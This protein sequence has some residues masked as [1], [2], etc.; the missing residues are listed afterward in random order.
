MITASTE[1]VEDE[2]QHSTE[3]VQNGVVVDDG[4]YDHSNLHEVPTVSY[5]SDDEEGGY[6]DR[7][8]RN[9]QIYQQLP[10]GEIDLMVWDIFL[11]KDHCLD[12]IRDYSVQQGVDLVR[13]RVDSYRFTAR[14]FDELCNWRIHA[15]RLPD[16]VS[17]AIKTLTAPH[18]CQRLEHNPMAGIKWCAGK[19]MEDIRANFEIPVKTLQ[20][21][22]LE[23]FGVTVPLSTMYKVRAEAVTQIQG[24]HDESYS[25]LPQYISQIKKADPNAYAYI[26][27]A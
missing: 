17:W 6:F 26:S 4:F 2:V 19:L 23:R 27:W 15:S 7:V 21:L 11:D 22:C 3:N 16:K 9:G 1:N 18:T 24:S 8:Y 5:G 20:E 10:F 14:C 12:A 25:K 13:D